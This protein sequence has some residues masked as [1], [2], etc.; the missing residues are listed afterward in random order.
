MTGV[1]DEW[2][3]HKFTADEK[4]L[5]ETGMEVVA[6]DFVSKKG[7]KFK[8]RVRYGKNDKGYMGIIAEFE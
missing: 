1:P 3:Q 2:C 7:N 5:L 6:D 8:A 4:A